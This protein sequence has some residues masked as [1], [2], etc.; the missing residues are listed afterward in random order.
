MAKTKDKKNKV[1]WEDRPPRLDLRGKNYFSEI[2]QW[3]VGEEYELVLK[4]RLTRKEESTG[5]E[6]GPIGCCGCDDDCGEDHEANKRKRSAGFE[7]VDIK[8]NG[9]VSATNNT[10]EGK[11][12]SRYNELVKKGIKPAQAM[13]MAKEGK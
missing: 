10:T 8:N 3:E 5:D 6:F 1:A 2:S 11:V 12:A 4:V 7:I 9:K 13:R